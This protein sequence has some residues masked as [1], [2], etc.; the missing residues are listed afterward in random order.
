MPQIPSTTY[1]MKTGCGSIFIHILYNKDQTKVTKV[2]A[3]LGKSGGCSRAQLSSY[4][5]LLSY[6]INQTKAKQ[7]T[8]ALQAASGHKC[9]YGDNCCIELVNRCVLEVFEELGPKEEEEDGE[10]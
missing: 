6:L 9:Q 8:G 5:E 2:H 1:E 7:I 4:C 3:N 10:Q